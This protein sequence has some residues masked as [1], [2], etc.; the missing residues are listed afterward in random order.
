MMIGIAG[1]RGIG[2]HRVADLQAV[3]ARQHEVEDDQIDRLAAQPRQHVA[4]G[5]QAL[6]RVAGAGQV[7]GN[8]LGDVEIVLDD[9][10]PWHGALG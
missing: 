6:H 2:A 10:N 7:V 1:G 9:Q 5:R 4:T 8:Q 3:E